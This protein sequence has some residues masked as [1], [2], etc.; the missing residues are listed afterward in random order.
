MPWAKLGTHIIKMGS[1]TVPSIG[2]WVADVETD[3]E[4]P[5]AELAA[6]VVLTLGPMTL[7]GKVAR[8]HAYQGSTRARV[9]GGH[10]GWRR[11][12]R[13]RYY[14]R[15]QGVPLSMVLGD[16]ARDTG[17]V[18]R[19]GVPDV[20]LGPSYV[21]IEG[22]GALTLYRL[23]L[24][25]YVGDDGVTVIGARPSGMVTSAFDP[26]AYD[27]ARGVV[28]VAT[29]AIGEWRPGR[30]FASTRLPLT[31]TI[32]GVFHRIESGKLRTDAWVA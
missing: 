17:E 6:S 2:A 3:D 28:T 32:G 29:E 26:M 19:L 27:T 8:G 9:V 10:D 23:G 7:V 16:L 20:S 11:T 15:A 30:T 4:V 5:E 18:V 31:L 12:V 21:R 1:C 25:W 24:P 22:A 13:A 14:I